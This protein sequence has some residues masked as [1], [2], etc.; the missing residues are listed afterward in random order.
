M[1]STT[2]GFGT[3]KPNMLR[4][5]IVLTVLMVAAAILG[6]A[7]RIEV[8]RP[9][10][11][12]IDLAQAVPTTFGN[13]REV[14]QRAAVVNPQTQQILDKLYSQTLSRTYVNSAGQAVMLS[15]AYGDDQRGGLQAHRPEVCYPAQGFKLHEAVD[16]MVP[17][18]HGEIPARRLVTSMGSRNEPITYWFNMGDRTV[19]NAVQKRWVEFR[20]LLT[21]QV[22]DGVLFRVSSIDGDNARAFAVHE[23]F[24]TDL[25]DAVAAP[26]RMRLAGLGPKAAAPQP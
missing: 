10:V 7:A 24:V 5:S 1:T 25:M 14:P 20:L 4:I 8:K 22:P 12:A 21:G 23:Q 26:N 2:I 18:R 3:M 15:L 16:R 19:K 13:W 9:P 6:V 11:P 17:T